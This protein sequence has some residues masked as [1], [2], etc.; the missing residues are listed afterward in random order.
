MFFE[1]SKGRWL[2]HHSNPKCVTSEA[3]LKAVLRYDFVIISKTQNILQNPHLTYAS[4][5]EMKSHNLN[6][7]QLSVLERGQE[8]REGWEI[9]FRES[10]VFLSSPQMV[11]KCTGEIL[12]ALCMSMRVWMRKSVLVISMGKKKSEFSNVLPCTWVIFWKGF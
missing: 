11:P 7:G 6:S 3:W 12:P 1:I 8:V 5:W 9:P 2:H 10:S 4:N